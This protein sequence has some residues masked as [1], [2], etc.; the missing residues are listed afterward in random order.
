MVP[1]RKADYDT[2]DLDL[3]NVSDKHES[4]LLSVTQQ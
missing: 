3:P 4:Q 1:S 2:K